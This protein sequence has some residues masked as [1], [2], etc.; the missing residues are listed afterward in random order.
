[1]TK[2]NWAII[3]TGWI[4]NDMAQTLIETNGEVY[5]VVNRNQEHAN[6]F[7]SKYHINNIYYSIDEMLK[8][9][10]VD[11][12]YIATPH[13]L[14]AQQIKD[15]LNHGKHVFCEKAITT[16]YQEFEEVYQLAKDKN[17]ILMEGFTLYNMPL[18]KDVQRYIEDGKIGQLKLVQVNF[19]SLKDPDPTKRYFSPDLAGGALYDIGGYAIAFAAMF[20]K[21]LE[22]KKTEVSF[23]ETDVDEMSGIILKNS[24]D[25]MAVI[26]LSFRAKQPKRGVVSGTKGY[27]EIDNYPRATQ[28]EITYTYDSQKTSKEILKSGDE[29]KALSYEV[30]KMEEYIDNGFDNGELE[31]SCQIS[32]IMNNVRDDFQMKFPFES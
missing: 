14:H 31:M 8:N 18:Y 28:A 2:Y 12:V 1:M 21:D 3:G 25:Q 30:L 22:V 11:I 17:L 6:E 10:E 13:H 27:I 29:S 23:Y 15:S 20:L 32:K 7:A 26:S 9:E 4:A 5:A 16:S 24:N 19:G